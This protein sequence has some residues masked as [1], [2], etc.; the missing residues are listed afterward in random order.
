LESGFPGRQFIFS[1]CD[2]RFFQLAQQRFQ[3]LG[4]RGRFYRFVSCGLDGPVIETC[5]GLA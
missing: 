5:P 4:D 2:K 3:Y 1:T